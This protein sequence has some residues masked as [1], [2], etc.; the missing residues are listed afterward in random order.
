MTHDELERALARGGKFVLYQYCISV[1]ILTF[2]R[3]S[4][5]YF[6]RAEESAVVR[7]LGFT[8]LSL[9]GGW[10]GIPWGPI[11][12]IQSLWV[13]LRGGRDVTDEV[14]TS[15]LPGMSGWE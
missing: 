15:L 12:T 11:Y 2:K 13:N 8:L 7:G 3:P 1:L 5:I 6:V 10:W 14:M 9:V 4:D